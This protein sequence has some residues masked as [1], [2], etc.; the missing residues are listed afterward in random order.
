MS[1]NMNA[2]RTAA[3]GETYVAG[4]IPTLQLIGRIF[5]SAIFLVAGVRKLLGVA[6]TTAYFTKLGFPAPE[7]V[8]WIAII[9]E[10]GAG[11]MLLFGWRTRIAA[12]ALVVFVVIATA[13]A[14]RFWEFEPA[15]MQNQVNHFLKNLAL[16]G[17]MLYVI[18]FGPGRLSLDKT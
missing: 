17:G 13:M 16:I 6:A 7:I 3:Y 18:A 15:Q 10:L 14:H 5:L 12:W 2:A 1:A 8:T 11:L 4:N 9:I